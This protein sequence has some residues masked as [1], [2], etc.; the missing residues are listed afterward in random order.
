MYGTAIMAGSLALASAW[1]GWT[2]NAMYMGEQIAN[3]KTEYATAQARAVEQ[4]HAETI[5]L[6]SIKDN[7]EKLAA[8]RQSDLA[9]D[10]A[11]GRDALVGLSHAAEG[12]LRS[13]QD[14][15]EACRAT[16][17]A[18]G[19]VLNQCGARLVEVA[20]AADGHLNDKLM[21]LDAWP[22]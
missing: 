17:A 9:R 13:A 14:S 2:L 6:Q 22:D 20:G 3:L 7:A 12:A 16:A 18:Q 19:V 4:A 8:K 5:R 15:H 21:L 10:V 1:A 11:A